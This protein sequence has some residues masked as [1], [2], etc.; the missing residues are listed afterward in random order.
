MVGK[1]SQYENKAV[2][3][4]GIFHPSLSVF[5]LTLPRSLVREV[6]VIADNLKADQLAPR[7]TTHASGVRIGD[8]LDR[9]E[10]HGYRLRALCPVWSTKPHFIGGDPLWPHSAG[11]IGFDVRYNHV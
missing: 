2:G 6:K 4:G 3:H 7:S 5:I 1:V 8:Y 9:C 11:Q 10:K